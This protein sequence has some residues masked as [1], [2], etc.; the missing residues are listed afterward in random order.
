MITRDAAAQ[1]TF[2]AG[3][4]RQWEVNVKGASASVRLARDRALEHHRPDT[5]NATHPAV[6]EV[7]DVKISQP[8]ERHILWKVQLRGGRRATVAAEGFVA[9]TSNGADDICRIDGSI[10]PRRDFANSIVETVR[11]VKIVLA[12]ESTTERRCEI[13]L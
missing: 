9:G 11:D 2:D 3:V 10:G 12:V 8:V 5:F 1:A 7:R 6:C 13:R 4:T